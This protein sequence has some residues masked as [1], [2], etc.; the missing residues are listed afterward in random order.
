MLIHW[1]AAMMTVMVLLCG[2]AAEVSRPTDRPMLQT[3]WAKDVSPLHVH[4]EYPRPQMVRAD[5][6]NL[7][8][9]WQFDFAEEGDAPPVGTKLPGEILVPFPVESQLSGIGKHADRL[10]YRRTFDIPAG[11]Q[12]KH[13]LLHFGA[14]DYEAQVWINGESLGIHRGGYDA[15]TFDITEALIDSGAQEI[16][17]GVWD[18]TDAGPQPRGKQVR[19]PKGIWY[20]PTT[21]IWQTVWLEPIPPFGRIDGLKLIPDVDASQLHVQLDDRFL[22]RSHN[23][24]VVVLDQGREVARGGG[25]GRVDVQIPDARLWSPDDPFLYDVRITLR[26]WNDPKQVIDRVDSYFG[27]RKIEVGPDAS[28]TTRLLLNGKPVFHIG[29]LDQGFWPDGLYTAPT[30]DALRHDVEMTKT[31]GFN[32][33]R[34]H[35]KVEPDRWYYW[36]D[37]LGL[38]VWQDMPSGDAYIAPGKGEINRSEQSAAQFE[39]ELTRLVVGMGNHPCIVMWV[40]F[41]EGWGQYDT[42]RIVQLIK[43]LDPT[44]LVN[45]A[46]G[47]NDVGAGDVHD[48]HSY[49][50]PACPVVEAN[51]A[52]VLGEFGGLGLAVDG[53]TWT[54]KTWGYRGMA[55]SDQLTAR[56]EAL[57]RRVW[58]LRDDAGLSAAIYTQITDVE[59]EC[60]GLLTYDREVVKVDAARIAAANRG[61][62]PTI[63]TIVETAEDAEVMWRYT[64][65]EPAAGWAE[66]GYDD[67]SWEQGP[68][69]FGRD[70]TPGAVVRTEWTTPDIWIRREFVLD[71]DPADDLQLL[72][73]HDEDAE[74][75]LNGVLAAGLTGYTTSYEEAAITGEAG[76]RLGPGRNTVAIHCRQTT[77]GQYI[78]AGLVRVVPRTN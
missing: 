78:D 23:V 65:D 37:V 64:F 48:I 74:I 21:G 57:M 66:P 3:P 52:A 75:Y 51:R 20:T 26:W 24:D 29:T 49:P 70:G 22:T 5:W 63:V 10:W 15:F 61:L 38:L 25:L 59:T 14:V 45:S 30:D 56:Y 32:T 16:V 8:G 6:L 44:R 13:V 19:D 73:H 62:L 31:L 55:D 9:L 67:S 77:G 2:C 18:P 58:K 46:S 36:C 54:D 33:I 28:G 11:W 43:E 17:V 47:W 60:N 50:G 53:H 42:A 71:A 35:V 1:L 76:D 39:R 69:G 12:G 34:K 68:A 40:P 4:S 72:V 27:M 41:N 7:N